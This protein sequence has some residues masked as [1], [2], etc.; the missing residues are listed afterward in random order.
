M[1]K[2]T[3]ECGGVIRGSPPEQCP[4]C[5]RRIGR[6]RQRVN[7][8]PLVVIGIFFASLLAFA[9]WLVGHVR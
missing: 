8:W 2:F 5:G 3:C 9:L 7:V 1:R 6:I 4:Q